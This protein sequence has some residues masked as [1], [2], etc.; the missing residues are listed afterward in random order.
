MCGQE[1]P[2]L[3]NDIY[4]AYKGKGLTVVG[5]NPGWSP[6]SPKGDD[7]MAIQRFADQGH[8]TFPVGLD[9]GNS[10]Q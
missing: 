9:N 1:F 7:L 10:Y 5:I 8:V 6:T 4:Q 3:E 2:G